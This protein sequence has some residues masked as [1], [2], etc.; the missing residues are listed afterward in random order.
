M[1]VAENK[2]YPAKYG[3]ARPARCVGG[4]RA[5]CYRAPSLAGRCLGERPFDRGAA[6]GLLWL[7]HTPSWPSTGRG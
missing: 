6:G 2:R 5:R 3:V 4:R 1:S 7:T